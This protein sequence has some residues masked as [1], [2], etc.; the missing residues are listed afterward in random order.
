MIVNLEKIVV[1]SFSFTHRVF[2]SDLSYGN[3]AL[4]YTDRLN[5]LGATFDKKSNWKSR[6]ES[7]LCRFLNSLTILNHLKGSK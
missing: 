7:T 1:Q 6:M 3:E 2:S 4:T 5:Y